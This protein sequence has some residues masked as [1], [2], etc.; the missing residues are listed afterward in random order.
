MQISAE[1]G[2]AWE[3]PLACLLEEAA[4]AAWEAGEGL[5]AGGRGSGNTASYLL[6]EEEGS[7]LGSGRKASGSCLSLGGAWGGGRPGAAPPLP[8]LDG[9]K[10]EASSPQEAASLLGGGNQWKHNRLGDRRRKMPAIWGGGGGGGGGG[11]ERRRLPLGAAWEAG[12]R[13][14]ACLIALLGTCQAA[15]SCLNL[16]GEEEEGLG[17]LSLRGGGTGGD[18]E[19]GGGTTYRCLANLG[20]EHLIWEGGLGSICITSPQ[21]QNIIDAYMEEEEEGRR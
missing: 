16:T 18:G 8:A 5:I 11:T 10:E 20:G 21:Q 7:L 15:A 1:E 4:W 2:S 12:R 13:L 19:E 17:C 14:P 3:V 9:R 6:W